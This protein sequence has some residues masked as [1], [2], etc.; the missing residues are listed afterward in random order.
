MYPV[1]PMLSS[2]LSGS[3]LLMWWTLS[4]YTETMFISLHT[5]A[6]CYFP[7][8]EYF[9]LVCSIWRI[10]YQVFFQHPLVLLLEFPSRNHPFPALSPGAL[11]GTSLYHSEMRHGT[12]AS[13]MAFCFPWPWWLVQGSACDS[14]RTRGFCWECWNRGRDFHH[15]TWF[16]RK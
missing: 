4:S 6:S 16:E 3:I 14:L 11:H 8:P 15:W 7:C 9:Q 12:R 13:E 1:Y 2:P 10:S 5:F